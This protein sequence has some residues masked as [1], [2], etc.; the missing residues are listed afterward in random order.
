MKGP[1]APA[2]TGPEALFE[3]LRGQGIEFFTGV[4]C[5]YF[6][7]L[8]RLI[9]ERCPSRYVPAA[10][11][12]TALAIACGTALTGRVVMDN[13]TYESTG[14]QPTTSGSTR[15]DRVALACGYLSA[16]R[17]ETIDELSLGVKRALTAPGPTLLAVQVGR[18]QAQRRRGRPQLCLRR[19]SVPAWKKPS[20]AGPGKEGSNAR[21]TTEFGGGEA[22]ELGVGVHDA[23]SAMMVERAGFDVLWL[24]SLEASA[25]LGLPDNNL[26]SGAEMADLVRQVR[27]VSVLPIYVDADNGYGSDELAVR[28][29]RMFTAAGASAMCIEDSAFPKRNS[30]R[31]DGDRHLMDVAEMAHRVQELRKANGIDIIARTE[32]LVAGYGMA[33]AVAR[34]RVYVEAGA[35]AVFVQVNSASKDLL[36]P[37]LRELQGMTRLVLAPTALPEVPAAEFARLGVSTMMFANVVLRAV[38][39]TLPPIL[40]RLRDSG[41]LADVS[42]AIAAIDT[43][44][45]LTGNRP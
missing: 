29:L 11:E 19:R 16:S 1:P 7:G 8:L 5:S 43:V 3:A 13:G 38:V 26:I 44:F 39:A 27:A 31:V 6:D 22:M 24:G 18:S 25:H 4:P 34:L 10:N 42:D 20:S 15:L 2:G 23:L 17:T 12:G 33:E 9:E 30:L 37:T 45:D 28:A 41:R 36:L 21:M 35:D 14:G 40:G 32:A